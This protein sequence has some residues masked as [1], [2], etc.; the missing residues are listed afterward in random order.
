MKK[1]TAI[2]LVLVMALGLVVLS[3]CGPKAEGEVYKCAMEPTFPPFD[4]TDENGELTGFDVDLVNAIAEDQGFTV[5][6]VNMGFDGL[7]TALQ[8][9]NID[10]IA[11]GMNA[12][13]ERREKVDFSDTYYESG[14]V[15]AVKADNTTIKSVDD[16]T[17]DMKVGVQIGTTGAD[18]AQELFEDGKIAEVK[19]YNGLDVAMMDLVNGAVA[20]V[21]NDEPV[22]KEYM[23]AKP[24]T[25]KIVGDTLNAESYGIA[26]QKGNTELLEKLNAGLKNI[27]DNGKF[28]E[29]WDKWLED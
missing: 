16:L 1:V 27:K 19:V 28:Q 25:I 24:G 18:L 6:W 9:G 26:V 21:I 15:V 2:L 12:S 11:S 22:T 20:A 7:I 17:K 8:G 10:M 29:I 5:E 13:P 4:T 3:G 14:L 23:N